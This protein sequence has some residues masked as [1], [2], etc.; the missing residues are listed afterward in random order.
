MNVECEVSAKMTSQ[1]PTDPADM[2]L[3]RRGQAGD[4]DAFEVRATRYG[5][6]VCS[7]ASNAGEK[8]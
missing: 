7:L 1:I 8:P 5:Q 2:G 4:L 6:R 3:V